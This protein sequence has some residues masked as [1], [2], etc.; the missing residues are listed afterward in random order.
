LLRLLNKVQGNLAALLPGATGT[1]LRPTKSGAAAG[2]RVTQA[3][4]AAAPTT[5]KRS[6][7]TR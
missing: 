6:E 5:R 2:R 3:R 7:A 1:E 4:G